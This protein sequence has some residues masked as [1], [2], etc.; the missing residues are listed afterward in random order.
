M[1][2]AQAIADIDVAVAEQI[3]L[4]DP[5]KLPPA[6]AKKLESAV[7][8]LSRRPI[9]SIF[10]EIKHAD[11]RRLDSLALEAIGFRKR[12]EREAVLE[13]VYKAVTRLVRGRLSKSSTRAPEGLPI[14][15]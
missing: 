11:R 15:D 1:T 12:F 6:L 5:R 14:S 3:L 10:E 7:V 13:K 8:E 4:P 2:G 9:Y